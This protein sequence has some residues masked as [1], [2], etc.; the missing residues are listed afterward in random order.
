[1]TKTDFKIVH[2]NWNNKTDSALRT[3]NHQVELEKDPI[4]ITYGILDQIFKVL[5]EEDIS[6]KQIILCLATMS[7]KSGDVIANIVKKPHDPVEKKAKNYP[8]NPKWSWEITSYFSEGKE[9]MFV[10]HVA[11]CFLPK[12]RY[13]RTYFRKL[14]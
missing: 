10:G 14:L 13:D 4:N 3:R 11:R 12:S 5:D 2:Y 1:M 6:A 8:K 7:K 9:E